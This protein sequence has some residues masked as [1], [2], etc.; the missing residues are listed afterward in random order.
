MHYESIKINYCQVGIFSEK[1]MVLES[2]KKY[3]G[4]VIYLN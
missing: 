4:T 3:R 2:V 1:K